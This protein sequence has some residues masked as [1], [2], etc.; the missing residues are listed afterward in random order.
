MYIRLFEYDVSPKRS[1]YVETLY[2]Y[3][4]KHK[5]IYDIKSLVNIST[6]ILYQ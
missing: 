5:L 6:N 2:Y 3:S 4:F 1:V